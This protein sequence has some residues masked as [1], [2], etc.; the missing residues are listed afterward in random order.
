MRT[1]VG[2]LGGLAAVGVI[3]GGI[4][5][6]APAASAQRA[7]S[8]TGFYLGANAGGASKKQSTRLSVENDNPTTTS[9]RPSFNPCLA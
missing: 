9:H 6:W 4:T 2:G 5:L 8:W 1:M 7:Y 3:C